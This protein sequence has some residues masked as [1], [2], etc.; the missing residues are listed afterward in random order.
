MESN[1][2]NIVSRNEC[3]RML[4][5]LIFTS[6]SVSCDCDGLAHT[7]N[8]HYIYLYVYSMYMS[9]MAIYCYRHTQYKH[10]TV[11]MNE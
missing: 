1:L 8:T 3:Q 11:C 7:H 4:H 5:C 10:Q 9:N 6:I 2:V